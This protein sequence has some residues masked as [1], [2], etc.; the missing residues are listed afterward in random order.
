MHCERVRDLL[1]A[2]RDGELPAAERCAVELHLGHCRPCGISLADDERIGK[3]IR[4]LGTT[5]PPALRASIRASLAHAELSE[6]AAGFKSAATTGI[7]FG[8]RRLAQY[9]AVI[10]AA[11]L[12]S[13]FATWWTV[14][15]SRSSDDVQRD[16]LNAHIRSL[17]QDSP[18]QIASSDQHTV[19]PWFSGRADFAPAVKDLS[20]DGYPL[21]GGRLDYVAGR[22]AGT[23]VYKRRLHIINVFMWPAGG[24]IEREPRLAVRNGYNL[25]TWTRT[26]LTYWAISDLNADEMMVLQRLL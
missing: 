14:D 21:A 9:A 12:I 26:G 20:A 11:C 24:A 4:L 18:V 10:A 8:T 3:S 25:L 1:G 6:S 23:V 22:R 13:I 16:V 7:G 2:Y 15:A 17:L 5:A 19:R